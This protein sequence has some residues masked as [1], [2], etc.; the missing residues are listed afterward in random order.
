MVVLNKKCKRH[1]ED[2]ISIIIPVYNLEK[3]I[4]NCVEMFLGQTYT[5]FELIFVNDASTDNTL[6]ILKSFKDSRIKIFNIEKS[7]AGIA[8]NFGLNCAKGER[9]IFF[10]GDDICEKTFL[11]KMVQNAQ[12]F[13]T[14]VTICASN[15]Y[16]EQKKKFTNHRTAHL[17]KTIDDN[18]QN[19]AKSLHEISDNSILELIEPWNKIYKKDFLISNN[20]KFAEIKN[21]EDLPFTYSVL[22]AAQKISFVKELLVTRRIRK[23]S[24]S[25]QTNENWINYFK[26]YEL[27]DNI[28]LKYKYFDEIKDAYLN[29]RFRTYAYFYKKAGILNKI[30]YFLKLL[31]EVKNVNNSFKTNFN[32]F[33]IFIQSLF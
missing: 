15:E 24:L 32:I 26:A 6:K 5:D 2:V 22:L 27:T 10:D 16:V 20:I 29:R 8:R 12:K 28:V 1:F 4:K 33:E 25:F 7:S 13:N 9:V 31:F 23:A 14:D 19:T 17:L 18:L 11:E 21:S 3:Y 30:P